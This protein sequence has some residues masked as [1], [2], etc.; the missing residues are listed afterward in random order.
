MINLLNILA[1]V[2]IPLWL[3]YLLTTLLAPRGLFKTLPQ[4]AIGY[5]LGIGVLSQVMLILGIFEIPLKLNIISH[6][7]LLH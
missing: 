1:G 5:G 6:H 3:G 4:L 2:A 7:L